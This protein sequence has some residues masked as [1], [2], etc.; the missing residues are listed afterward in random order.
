[1]DDSD[2]KLRTELDALGAR[3]ESKLRELQQQGILHGAAREEAA[4]LQIQHARLVSAA[5]AAHV[6]AGK[7]IANEISSD[8][9]ILKHSFT[10]WLARVDKA[11]ERPPKP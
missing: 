1:M 10:R 4:D 9:E 6:S 11:S 7:L 8:V 5:G 3:I 2:S